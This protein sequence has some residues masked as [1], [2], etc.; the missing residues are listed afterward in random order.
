MDPKTIEWSKLEFKYSYTPYRFQ[1]RW[2]EGR[3]CEERLVTDNKISIDE[4]STCLHYGQEIFEGM[5][6]QRTKD[7]RVMLFRPHENAARFR[8]SAA[9]I[10]MAEVPED[11]FMRGITEVVKANLDYVPPYG[12]GAS[13]YIRPFQ[14]GV[15]ENLGVKPAPEY[16]FSVFVCPVGPYFKTGFKTIKLKIDDYYD[17]AARHGIGPA[18]AG[19]NYSASLLPLKIARDEGFNE[20]VYLDPVE[21]KYFEETGASNVFFV[22]KDGSLATPKSESILE[23]I[24]RRSL[25]T[26]AGE[27]FG[28]NMIERRVSVDEIENIA[29]MGAC[30]TAA[31]ITPVG[32]LGYRGKTYKLYAD[33]QEAGPI[34]TK[35]YK[36]LTAYQI[37]DVPDKFGWLEEVK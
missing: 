28:L 1:A 37:G 13:L 20:I 33:G 31:V 9:R 5:K 15:G 4:G 7:G 27:E 11:L 36:Y 24:T 2:K 14:I 26:V 10:L 23:S 21:H 30:G 16:I 3:W 29:E 19:G 8:R 12:T 34:T 6:A 18:K 35:L 22:F 32:C 17:R 25:I